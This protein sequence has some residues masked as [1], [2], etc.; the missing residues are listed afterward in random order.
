M[1]ATGETR[2]SFFLPQPENKPSPP[3][4]PSLAWRATFSL[5]ARVIGSVARYLT[6]DN[7]TVGRAYSNYR[8]DRPIEKNSKFERAIEIVRYYAVLVITVSLYQSRLDKGPLYVA[9][10]ERHYQQSDR[11]MSIYWKTGS[12]FLF[13]RWTRVV[14]RI[15]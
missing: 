3:P 10:N 1:K 8:N 2:L 12:S 4:F 15:L 5:Y 13:R 6:N 14:D 9:C 7:C 11:Y